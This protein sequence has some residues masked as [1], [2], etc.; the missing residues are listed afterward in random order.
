MPSTRE[1]YEPRQAPEAGPE[2]LAL[3]NLARAAGRAARVP[4][5]CLR[6]GAMELVI[7][8]GAGFALYSLQVARDG[9]RWRLRLIPFPP[10]PLLRDLYER[11]DW[12]QRARWLC[13]ASSEARSRQV[14]LGAVGAEA[15]AG[16]ASGE[17]AGLEE[18]VYSLSLAAVAAATALAGRSGEAARRTAADVERARRPSHVP[19]YLLQRALAERLAAGPSPRGLCDVA[20][21]G[22]AARLMRQLGLLDAGERQRHY[23]R[24]APRRLAVRLCE[25]LEL[26]PGEVGL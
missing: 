15:R 6:L 3:A 21:N 7:C 17:V 4:L 9:A 22:A 20:R 16:E 1:R 18:G 2:A 25:A 26:A 13:L 10:E 23:A 5:A 14:T 19:L 11:P 24:V 12:A 8:G